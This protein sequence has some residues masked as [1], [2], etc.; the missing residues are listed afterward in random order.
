MSHTN[1]PIIV[2]LGPTAG[3]KT[4]LSLTLAEQLPGNGEIISADSM[5]IYRKM[6]IGTAKPTPEQLARV[7]HHLIDIV[8]PNEP[9]TVND[10]SVAAES[11]IS[12]IRNRRHWPIVVGGTN[13]YLKVL[14]EGIFQG[15]PADT[16]FRTKVKDTPLNQL[17]DRLQEIDPEAASQIH[18]NDRKRIIRAIEVYQQTGKPISAM[19]K[20]WDSQ[21]GPRS[22]AVLVGLTWDVESLN[23]RINARV[24]QM[25]NEGFVEEVIGLNKSGLFDIQSREA[26]GYKQILLYLDGA[27]QLEDAIERIKIETR[28]YARKQRTWMKRFRMYGKSIW[29]DMPNANIDKAINNIIDY[30]NNYDTL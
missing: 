14:L 9:F 25:I 30:C 23:K 19:Q 2:I 10:W 28:R 16:A 8:E 5:Q 1:H 29:L 7:P 6:N 27:M 12:E 22:D 18:T 13:L 11:A 15:P 20:Q 26:L 21:S 3:G 4:E 24:K 17:H